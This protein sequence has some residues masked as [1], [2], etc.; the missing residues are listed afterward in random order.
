MLSLFF[1]GRLSFGS[2][3][4]L[5][6]GALVFALALQGALIVMQGRLL[7]P[8]TPEHVRWLWVSLIVGVL[9]L[10]MA[11]A[12]GPRMLLLGCACIATAFVGLV[13]PTVP[14]EA[15]GIVDGTLKV[16]FGAWLFSTKP[17]VVGGLH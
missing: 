5:Q 3:T 4:P 2:P 11:V 15:F 10:P 17:A 13:V 1:A 8:T 14:Y 6:I 9:F 12:F 16:G 7:P